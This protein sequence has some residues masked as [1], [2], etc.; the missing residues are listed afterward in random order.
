MCLL[1]VLCISV[2][3]DIELDNGVLVLTQKNWKEALEN[4]FILVEFCK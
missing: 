1:S 4:E 2:L 3:A